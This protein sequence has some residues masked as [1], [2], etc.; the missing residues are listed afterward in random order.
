MP[1]ILNK[2]DNRDLKLDHKIGLIFSD[3]PVM[4]SINTNQQEAFRER[5]HLVCDLSPCGV[6]LIFRQG[7]ES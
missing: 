6:T 2:A 4:I 5:R 7:Q 1:E 3:H